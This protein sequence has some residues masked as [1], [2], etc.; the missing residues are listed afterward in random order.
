MSNKNNDGVKEETE[1]KTISE[2]LEDIPPNQDIS[3]SDLSTTIKTPYVRYNE[4]NLP[5]L[6]LHCDHEK[7]NGTRFFRCDQNINKR[8][9]VDEYSYLYVTYYCSNC[10][11]TGKVYSLAAKIITNYKPQ[12]ECF[13]FGEYPPYG[14]P[15]PAKLIELIGPDR[16]EFLKGRRCENQGLG[17]G[18]FVYYRRVVENQKDRILSEI[19]KVLEKIGSKMDM[20]DILKAAVQE[21]QFSK[22]LDMAK[23]ALPESLLVNGHSPILL[24]YST[25]SEG[26]HSLDDEECLESARSV[27]IVLGELS[28]RLSQALKDEDELK[29]AISSLMKKKKKK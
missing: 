18:A 20:I 7:C 9:T 10:Q 29:K 6:Q 21:T 12:G 4:M 16:E 3:I 5:E 19:I 24:L 27:R 14:P 8:L 11:E 15:V 1:Y 2:F 23:D 28:E 25:L 13:K 22:A 26:V 17:V